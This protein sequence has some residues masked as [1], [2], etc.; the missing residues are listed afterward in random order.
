[1]PCLVYH[2]CWDI[3]WDNNESLNTWNLR[4]VLFLCLKIPFSFADPLSATID[5][6]QQKVDSNQSAIFNCTV[7][8]HPIKSVFWMKDGFKISPNQKVKITDQSVLTIH[9]VNKKDQGMYQC[10][11]KNEETSSQG[12]A[13]LLLGGTICP[14]WQLT[15]HICTVYIMRTTYIHGWLMAARWRW[16]ALRVLCLVS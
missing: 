11:V 8:G 7:L 13:Q 9:A 2:I 10:V 6:Q 3:A 15:I 4:R 12:T 16:V 14:L 1:M 5:P